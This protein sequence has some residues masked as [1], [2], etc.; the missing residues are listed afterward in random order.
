MSPPRYTRTPHL[1]DLVAESERFAA[2]VRAAPADQRSALRTQAVSDAAVASMRLD[3]SRIEVPPDLAATEVMAAVDD[4]ATARAAPSAGDPAAAGAAPAARLTAAEVD[5]AAAGT[6]SSRGGGTWLDVLARDPDAASAQATALEYLGVV[7]GLESDDLADQLL[8]APHPAVAELHRRVTRGLL[9]PDRQGSW[10]RS[11]QAVHDASVGRVIY[12]PVAPAAI[13]A[14][15]G[16]LDGWLTSTGA[17]EHALV[18]SGVLHLELLRIHPFEAANGRV[19]RAAARLTLRARGLDPQALAAVEVELD[20]DPVGYYEEVAR[21][22]RRRDHTIW[23]ERWGDAVTAALRRRARELGQLSVTPPERARAFVGDRTSPAFTL[24]DY[25]AAAGANP[26][27]ARVELGA[28]LDA[29]AVRRV[30]GS[31]GL[32]FEVT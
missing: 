12:Y 26:Q 30:H 6:G 22:L 11:E 32:R 10:R 18:V 27:Q 14:A 9:E 5:P 1:V 31:R 3:G 13:T 16:E 29:G 21:T 20:R 24:A 25:R 8:V 23:L 7:A 17:R 19:A 15:V 2:M 28:L 4:P